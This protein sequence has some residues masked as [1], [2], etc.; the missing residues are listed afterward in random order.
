MFRTHLL[1]RPTVFSTDPEFN[2]FVLQGEGR[3]FASSYPAS[4][5]RLLGPNSLLLITDDGPLHK[6][7]HGLTWSFTNSSALKDQHCR[8]MSDIH[9]HVRSVLAAWPTHPHVIHIQDEAKK[10][11][12]L[13][14]L[15]PKKLTSSISSSDSWIGC[16]TALPACLAFLPVDEETMIGS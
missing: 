1:G 11:L 6:Q 12:S 7:L 14:L 2:R 9:C 4:L 3:L 13:S 15:N 16:L 10:V 8:L 5:R